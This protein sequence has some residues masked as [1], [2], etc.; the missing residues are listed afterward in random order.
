MANLDPSFIRAYAQRNAAEQP[1]PQSQPTIDRTQLFASL[2]SSISTDDEQVATCVASS[3]PAE[4]NR[5]RNVDRRAINQPKPIQ[6]PKPTVAAPSSAWRPVNSSSPMV[7]VE[8]DLDWAV[9]LPQAELTPGFPYYDDSPLI[10]DE[11]LESSDEEPASIPISSAEPSSPL[12]AEFEVDRFSWPNRVEALLAEASSP[13]DSVL[14]D[15]A[16]AAAR[17][18]NVLLLAGERRGAG[19]STVALCL[20]RRLAA[21]DFRVALV[22][23]DF[24]KPALA[25]SLGLAPEVGWDDVLEDDESL[26]SAMVESVEE[27]LTLLPLRAGAMNEAL[28]RSKPTISRHLDELARQF[29][30]VLIDAGAQS[31]DASDDLVDSRQ[32]ALLERA[33]ESIGGVLLVRD[34]RVDRAHG[35]RTA[36]P[37]SRTHAWR[38][39]GVVENFT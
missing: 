34:G 19:T 25:E 6:P 7:I 22:D 38:Q 5:E 35:P 28:D 16:E 36:R 32:I 17:G 10:D 11:P 33:G 9:R 23:G 2:T 39:L 26:S 8:D 29:D 12:R 13:L 31:C 30:V 15:V 21:S 37:R 18:Q 20:A 24:Q 3:P 14:A 4:R 27:G 1:A